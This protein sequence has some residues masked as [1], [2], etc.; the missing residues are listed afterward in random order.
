MLF[1]IY[2][3]LPPTSWFSKPYE[4][5]EKIRVCRLSGY[6]AGPYCDDCDSIYICRAGTK[7]S[8]CP[9]HQLIHLTRDLKYRANADCLPSDQLVSKHWFILPPAME[10]FYKKHTIFYKELTLSDRMPFRG[11]YT[12]Y[13]I[14]IPKRIP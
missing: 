2:G 14:N 9:F 12:G 6:K 8:L 4:D 3:S 13:G 1:R 11:G 10:W 7:T 5:L